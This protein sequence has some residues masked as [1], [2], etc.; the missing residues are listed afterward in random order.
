[1][2]TAEINKITDQ[3]YAAAEQ[4]R[5]ADAEQLFAQ[6]CEM[7]GNNSEAW[8]MRGA[9]QFER[10]AT[11]VASDYLNRALKLNPNDIEAH[12][13]L[14]KLFLSQGRLDEAI[15]SGREAVNLDQDY[16]EAW[17]LLSAAHEK[18]GQ[19]PDAE[20][21]SR[22]AIAL[23]PESSEAK[24][25]LVNA[26]R[27]QDKLDEAILL[28]QKI[29]NEN[30]M[31]PDIWYYLG[32]A[33]QSRRLLQDSEQCFTKVIELNPLHAGAHRGLGNTHAAQG[34]VLQAV[35]HYKKAKD[36]NPTFPRLHFDLGKVLLPSSSEEHR[37][38]LQQLQL[39]YLYRGAGEA[40]DIAKKLVN[41]FKYDD[42]SALNNLVHFFS[43]F[44]PARVY[45]MAWWSNALQQYGPREL[46]H[47]TV[48]RSVFSAVFS[49]SL[50]CKEALEE[51]VNFAEGSRMSS[52]GSGAGYWEYLLN[53]NYGVDIVCHDMKLR[54]RF[55]DT[56]EQ[57][58]SHATIHP[59]DTV[60]LAW[61]PGESES[62]LGIEPLLNHLQAGQKLVLIGEP[63]DD[64]GQPRTCGTRRFFQF[65]RDNFDHQA[66]IL[67]ANYAYLEDCVELL[68]RKR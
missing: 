67:L 2:N 4:G 32:L 19:Y 62:V 21:C 45:P 35:L 40:S 52:H 30:P 5:L 15:A 26:L 42:P 58:H 43:E 6:V 49:W 50:P 33:F 46:A 38:L 65:L 11:D 56:K 55:I 9:I 28:C 36:L 13:T 39:D 64:M 29:R 8:M 22:R 16:G 20:E 59:S 54:H 14:C 7:N 24:I 60:F 12:F 47:D 48:M 66:T 61:V 17:L 53:T 25:T 68:T 34:N 31:Q 18:T 63:P 37:Q 41:N 10:G 44:D 51:I 57:L 23:L 3:A 1:M 27:C